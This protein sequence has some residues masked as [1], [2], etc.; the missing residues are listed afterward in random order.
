[1]CFLSIIHV[2]DSISSE[3]DEFQGLVL[4]ILKKE[5]VPEFK[6]LQGEET[7][8]N[9]A[10]K[11]VLVKSITELVRNL[12]WLTALTPKQE[13][14]W[15]IV[16]TVCSKIPV[17]ADSLGWVQDY[18]YVM[19]QLCHIYKAYCNG[20]GLRGEEERR[21]KD[22]LPANIRHYDDIRMYVGRAILI[23]LGRGLSN[24]V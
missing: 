3:R 12:N 20:Q 13:F 10:V 14:C 18:D 8:P 24:Y 4:T 2:Q 6:I 22:E 1:M 16:A 17:K 21:L 9:T 15:G 7:L 11:N 5:V 19:S 23:L